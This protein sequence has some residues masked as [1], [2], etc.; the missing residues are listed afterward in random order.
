M[1]SLDPITLRIEYFVW[2]L[3]N[4]IQVMRMKAHCGQLGTFPVKMDLCQIIFDIFRYHV[5][6]VEGSARCVQLSGYESR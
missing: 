3:C 5:Y 4:P 2:K 1:L 6:Y